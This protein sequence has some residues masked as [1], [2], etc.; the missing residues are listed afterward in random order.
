MIHIAHLPSLKRMPLEEQHGEDT[1]YQ[2][3]FEDYP[4]FGAVRPDSMKS[5]MGFS[6]VLIKPGTTN[7][8]HVHDDQEQVYFVQQGEGVIQI[9]EETADVK[10]GDS[11]FLPVGVPHGFVNNSEKLVILL[12]IGTRV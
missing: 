5:F 2:I 10:A 9:G 4:E 11:I 1:L 6:R 3:F 12:M 7:Q 8:M